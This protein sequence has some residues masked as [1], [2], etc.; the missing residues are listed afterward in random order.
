MR[1]TRRHPLFVLAVICALV[2]IAAT[3]VAETPRLIDYFT[4]G[5]VPTVTEAAEIAK[6]NAVAKQPFKVRVRNGSMVTSRGTRTPDYVAG[7]PPLAYRG[8]AGIDGPTAYTWV[9]PDKPPQAYWLP[10]A[11]ITISSGQVVALPG[12]G[13]ATFTVSGNTITALVHVPI[14]GGT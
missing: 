12:G 5:Q 6:L 13:S 8:D 14:D 9:D 4:R 3:A 11:Q 7:Y 1:R 2:P 10:G